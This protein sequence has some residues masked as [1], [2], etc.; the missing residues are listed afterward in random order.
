MG[1]PDNFL[2]SHS[3]VKATQ[4]QHASA[5]LLCAIGKG[6]LS[7]R[8]DSESARVGARHTQREWQQSFSLSQVPYPILA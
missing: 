1:R 3:G 5:L 2:R 4:V 6:D 8:V 7:A